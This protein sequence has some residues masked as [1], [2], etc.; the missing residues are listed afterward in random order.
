MHY[1]YTSHFSCR[2]SCPMMHYKYTSHFSCR[3]TCP[4]IHCKH[5]S[6][7]SCRST[8]PMIHCKHTSHFSCRSRCPMI[9]CK[10]TSHFSCRSTCPMMYCK[11]TS[12][13]SCR[14]S[15]SMMHCKHTSHFSCRSSCS[16]MH[17]KHT[18]RFTSLPKAGA[19]VS[20]CTSVV[21]LPAKR[22]ALQCQLN[23]LLAWCQYT[24]TGQ[25]CKSDLQLLSESGSTYN[26]HSRSIPEIHFACWDAK[27]P[28]KILVI[29]HYVLH[30]T[31]ESAFCTK[32]DNNADY[33]DYNG[34]KEGDEIKTTL[35]MMTVI[36][37]MMMITA[38]MT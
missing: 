24:V 34:D 15:C 5:T 17:C 38:M 21:T 18:S 4:M 29:L 2:S 36:K 8:C 28:E 31:Q 37:V 32:T 14:S 7:F 10:H 6:H 23:D 12:H 16:M 33:N 13:F 25:D 26:R 19:A 9:H 27:Q 35:M 30:N 20:V 3:S 11:H 22:L 1:K